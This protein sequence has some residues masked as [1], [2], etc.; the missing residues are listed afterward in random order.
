MAISSTE[1]V[2]STYL[3]VAAGN[4]QC[5]LPGQIE[6][7]DLTASTLTNMS[8]RTRSSDYDSDSDSDND[9]IFYGYP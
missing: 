8:W 7:A 2:P 3:D 4:Q 1:S 9:A 5:S 6:Y